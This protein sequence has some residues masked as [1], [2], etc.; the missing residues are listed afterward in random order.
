MQD[1]ENGGDDN[2]DELNEENDEFKSNYKLE[3][4]NDENSNNQRTS[5]LDMFLNDDNED[6]VSGDSVLF[7]S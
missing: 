1:I 4:I 7:I 5:L 6:S 3:D 2:L